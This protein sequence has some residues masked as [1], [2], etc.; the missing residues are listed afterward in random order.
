[1]TFKYYFRVSQ[2]SNNNND[3]SMVGLLKQSINNSGFYSLLINVFLCV[4]LPNRFCSVFV[5]YKLILYILVYMSKITLINI[6][7]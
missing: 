1:M 5:T 7:C 2:T 4:I 6:G 3:N